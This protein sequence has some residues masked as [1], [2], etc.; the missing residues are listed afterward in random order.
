MD[1]SQGE[2]VVVIQPGSQVEG[3]PVLVP[4][5]DFLADPEVVRVVAEGE[6][7]SCFHQFN[8]AFAAELMLTMRFSGNCRSLR[9][10]LRI[11]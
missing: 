11:T 4:A 1:E 5:I 9:R 8:P 6:R 3:P 7:L 2:S 10:A